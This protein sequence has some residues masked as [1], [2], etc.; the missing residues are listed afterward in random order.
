MRGCRWVC[1]C[2]LWMDGCILGAAVC[3]WSPWWP[4]L[5]GQLLPVVQHLQTKVER[6]EERCQPLLLRSCV[7]I[8]PNLPRGIGGQKEK[9]TML[10]IK[11]SE[12]PGQRELR[13]IRGRKIWGRLQTFA[14]P[15]APARNAAKLHPPS[16]ARQ[17][18][19][20]LRGEHLPINC[21]VK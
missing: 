16:E 10:I 1:L 14:V 7:S 11:A 15:G 5:A 2:L 20:E 3:R 18:P 9:L 21:C 6:M 17:S 13:G 8:W 19:T 12:I 4:R